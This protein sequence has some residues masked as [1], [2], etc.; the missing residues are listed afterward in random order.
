MWYLTFLQYLLRLTNGWFWLL[1]HLGS[2][3]LSKSRAKPLIHFSLTP[4]MPDRDLFGCIHE[5]IQVATTLEAFCTLPIRRLLW[6]H[7][8]SPTV[9]QACFNDLCW[10]R[11][12]WDI[13]GSAAVTIC[14]A[15]NFWRAWSPGRIFGVLGWSP[16]Q[17]LLLQKTKDTNK[18]TVKWLVSVDR[19]DH[20]WSFIGIKLQ[21]GRMNCKP[22]IFQRTFYNACYPSVSCGR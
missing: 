2:V 6:V 3:H 10:S 7:V 17:S 5:V 19:N 18:W 12:K 20:Y 22:P 9:F 21:N 16:W 13:P 1:P 15:R 11:E 14:P 8:H 4:E